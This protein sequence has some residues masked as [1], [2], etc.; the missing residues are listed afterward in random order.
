VFKSYKRFDPNYIG[1]EKSTNS[2]NSYGV[3]SNWYVDSGATDHVT[4]ELDN[5][6]MKDNYTGSDKIY[7]ANGS[8]MYIKH[9][10]QSTI[11]TPLCDL[12]LNNVLHVPQAS[13]NLASIHRIA[14]DNNIFFKLH[15]HVFFIK[16]RESRKTLL[17]NKARG[18]LYRLPCNMAS[19]SSK[20]V[21][22]SSKNSTTRW[23]A[24]LGH[25]SSST[26]RLVLSKNN[27]P[28]SSELS[29]EPVC[30]ACQQAK[31]HQ[32]PYP[33]SSSVSKSPLEFVFYDVWGSACDSIERNKYY[34]SFIDDFSKFIWIY[35]LKHKSESFKKSKN[36]RALLNGCLTRK[37]LPFKPTGMVNI[38]NYIPSLRRLVS[39]IT[40]H[41]LML[42]GKMAQ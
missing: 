21:L 41:V 31:S 1:E 39:L 6:T 27:L 40:S 35:L 33:R 13:K 16:D 26:V 4:G 20:H 12:K 42:T 5:L 3:D 25:P 10:G 19:T 34:V 23:H 30:D 36:Y 28:C 7:M 15:P 38:K 22:S 14:F 32:L 11:H 24:R 18:G 8:G 37:F 17:H 2:L 29:H 9:I